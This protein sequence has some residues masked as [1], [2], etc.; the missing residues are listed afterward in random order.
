FTSPI[1]RYPDLI[2]HR[3]L[4]AVLYDSPEEQEGEIRIGRYPGTS[5]SGTARS[6]QEAAATPWSK[7]RDGREQ[8][9]SKD[10]GGP[11]SLEEL[12]DIAEESSQAERRA[13]DAER[14]LMEWK[15]AKF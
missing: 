15:K 7:R 13:D 9:D 12:H 11:L 6:R 2:V 14:E 5:A 8:R 4:K 3:I 10:L 1:R